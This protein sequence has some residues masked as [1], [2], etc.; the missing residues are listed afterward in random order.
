[1][2]PAD[3]LVAFVNAFAVT[4]VSA[5]AQAAEAQYGVQDAAAKLTRLQEL[6]G[7]WE[8]L[9]ADVGDDTKAIEA[10]IQAEIWDKVDFST[11]GL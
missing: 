5:S 1:M 4:D 2:Q 11:Y 9:L 3:D 8:A 6:V 10:L 7:R